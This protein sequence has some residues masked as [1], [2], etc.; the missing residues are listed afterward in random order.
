MKFFKKHNETGSGLYRIFFS[1]CI[2]VLCTVTILI[3]DNNKKSDVETVQK[4]IAT[5]EKPKISDDEIRMIVDGLDD[6]ADSDADVQDVESMRIEE[7]TETNPQMK[8]YSFA[9][10][11]YGTVGKGY[12]AQVPVYSE[13]LDDW[14]PHY[15]IDI[16]CPY[17]SE[18]V[19]CEEGLVSEIGYDINLGNYVIV[20]SGEYSCKYASLS[21]DI[22]VYE[23]QYIYRGQ[24]ISYVT[25][26]CV[27][28]ICDPPHLHF[29]MKYEDEY[30]NPTEY[31]YFE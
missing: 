24:V 25:D 10:P 12:S 7:K 23:G 14:R 2:F 28:E 29:E 20:E 30:V 18:V 4:K 27:S 15:G 1:L 31:V 17:E 9:M 3:T 8:E 6:T 13:T 26:S 21:S 11:V 22:K 19:S 16:L 5:E